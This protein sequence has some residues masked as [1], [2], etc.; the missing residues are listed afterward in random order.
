MTRW[1]NC[2]FLFSDGREDLAY[3]VVQFTRDI[4]RRSSSWAVISFA[5]RC[6]RSR[7]F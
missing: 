1:R 5:D 2:Q 4:L 7:V 6:W 3:F